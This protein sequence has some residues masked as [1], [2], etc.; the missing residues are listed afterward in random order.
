LS[1]KKNNGDNIC[2]I[3]LEEIGKTKFVF[4]KIEEINDEL[5]N[6]VQSLFI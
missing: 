3:L 1:D 2:F 4:K 6:I 5:K